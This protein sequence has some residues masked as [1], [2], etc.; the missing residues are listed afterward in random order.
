LSRI[1]GRTGTIFVETTFAAGTL[2]GAPSVEWIQSGVV[3]VLVWGIV[4]VEVVLIFGSTNFGAS[5]EIKEIN[6]T[7]QR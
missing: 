7:V 6:N 4:R 1:V 5:E 2:R 3:K